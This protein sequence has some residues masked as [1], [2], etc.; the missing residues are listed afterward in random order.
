MYTTTLNNLN[1]LFKGK[2]CNIRAFQ[3]W[4]EVMG[5]LCWVLL[6]VG[7]LH[8]QTLRCER[9]PPACPRSWPP[10][11]EVSLLHL[12]AGLSH[13]DGGWSTEKWTPPC[14]PAEENTDADSQG[15]PSTSQKNRS[16]QVPRSSPPDLRQQTVAGG[17]VGLVGEIRGHGEGVVQ[18]AALDLQHGFDQAHLGH[19]ASEQSRSQEVQTNRGAWRRLGRSTRSS[20]GPLG[21]PYLAWMGRDITSSPTPCTSTTRARL[22]ICTRLG[23]RVTWEFREREKEHDWLST[24]IN[25]HTDHWS[26]TAF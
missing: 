9:P 23:H 14:T 11:A 22:H 19:H 15:T 24:K 8:C 16:L 5:C 21:V 2:K 18:E 3:E 12:A 6:P 26:S 1:R 17:Q 20:R 7:V 4:K 25:D 13:G 10:E